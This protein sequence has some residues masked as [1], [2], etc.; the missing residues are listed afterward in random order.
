MTRAVASP[1]QC[2]GPI[3]CNAIRRGA[4]RRNMT[5]I[6]ESYVDTGFE[7]SGVP[8]WVLH[9]D[10]GCMCRRDD[11]FRLVPK[12]LLMAGSASSAAASS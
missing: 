10:S 12:G 5:E 3:V 8:G 6:P 1:S 7:C 2:F 11:Q 9:G 4:P